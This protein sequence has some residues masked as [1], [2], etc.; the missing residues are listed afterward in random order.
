MTRSSPSDPD[1]AAITV[2]DYRAKAFPFPFLAKQISPSDQEDRPARTPS[3]SSLVLDTDLN[4]SPIVPCLCFQRNSDLRTHTANK[5]MQIRHLI[6]L[7]LHTS[8]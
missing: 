6:P 5:N 4:S 2:P 3:V 1:R 7:H 8:L